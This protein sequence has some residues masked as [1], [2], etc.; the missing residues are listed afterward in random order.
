MFSTGEL[1]VFSLACWALILSPGPDMLYVITRGI[2]GGRLA[3]VLSAAGVISG[4]LVHT[5]FAACGLSIILKTSALVFMAVKVAG[6]AYLIYLGVQALLNKNLLSLQKGRS[7]ERPG[8]LFIQGMMSN[9]LNPK[10]AIFF[11][12][13]LPQF[14]DPQQSGAAL[15]MTALGL[16]FACFGLVFLIPLGYFA[17]RVGAWLVQRPAISQRIRY[18]TGSVLIGLGLK[19]AVSQRG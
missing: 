1:M 5:L 13:F 7:L 18:I 16:L 3:G 14:V 19:L 8:R 15:R 2:S 6:A 10:I 4:T 17:G 12:A 9:L 11:L